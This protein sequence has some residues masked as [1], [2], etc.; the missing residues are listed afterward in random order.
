MRTYDCVQNAWIGMPELVVTIEKSYNEEDC[1]K[2]TTSLGDWRRAKGILN[3]LNT[4]PELIEKEEF[5][6]NEFFDIVKHERSKGW[7]LDIRN[8]KI[9]NMLSNNNN[10]VRLDEYPNGKDEDSYPIFKKV[11]EENFKVKTPKYEGMGT[12][13]YFAVDEE[14]VEILEDYVNMFAPC[15]IAREENKIEKEKAKLERLQKMIEKKKI[16]IA[17]LLEVKAFVEKG[18]I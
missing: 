14:G 12:R 13:Y 6:A 18:E 4:Y 9:F 1:K 5:T 10:G 3:L 7:L 16:K 2:K 17:N 15:L 8:L 11:R